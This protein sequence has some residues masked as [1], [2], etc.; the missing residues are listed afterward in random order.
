ME[1]L[2][3]NP[4]KNEWLRMARGVSFDDLT[5]HGTFLGTRRHPTRANQQIMLFEYQG[6]VWAVPFVEDRKVCFLKTLYPSRKYTK[7][8]RRGELT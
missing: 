4:L 6:R 1:G 3:W 7:L 8:H 5:D 2:Q